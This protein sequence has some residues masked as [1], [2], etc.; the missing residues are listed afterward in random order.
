V[1]PATLTFGS[2]TIN[3]TAPNQVVYV[4]NSGTDALSITS[5]TAGGDFSQ[6]NNCGSTVAAGASC[7]IA[8]SF[9]P[10][11]TGARTGSI[12]IVDTASGTT[13]TV[14]LSGTGQSAPA[15][16]GG[17]PSGSYT[18]TINGTVGTLSNFGTV[19]LTVQ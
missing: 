6:V 17:T 2:Q 14:A 5:I 10:T 1:F 15:T 7:A 9:T 16:T 4:T 18:L 19:T 13:H 11:V 8:V 3:T 12:T